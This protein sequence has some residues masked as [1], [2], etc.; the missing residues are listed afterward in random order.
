MSKKQLIMRDID[1][2]GTASLIGMANLSD[3]DTELELVFP[4]TSLQWREK[5][6][7]P[8]ACVVLEYNLPC[9]IEDILLLIERGI[10][11]MMV[12]VEDD[13]E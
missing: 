3:A 7:G 6:Q 1:T 5:H 4:Q 10:K 12:I 8:R 13:Q 9:I 11:V 2:F